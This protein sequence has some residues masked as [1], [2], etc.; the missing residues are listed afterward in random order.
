MYLG[1][2]NILPIGFIAYH[3]VSTQMTVSICHHVSPSD[4]QQTSGM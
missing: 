1:K 2:Y 4:I 3:H